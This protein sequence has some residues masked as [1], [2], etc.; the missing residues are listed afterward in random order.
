MRTTVKDDLLTGNPLDGDLEDHHIFPYCLTKS[1]LSSA[2][3][4]SI[5]NKIIVAKA[6]NRNISN[7]NPDKYLV[8][9]AND[10]INQGVDGDL[11]RRF[12]N[13]FI[14]YEPTDH[15]LREK[16]SKDNYDTFLLDRAELLL[17]RIREVV[18][19]SWQEPT[20][21]EVNLEDD[22]FVSA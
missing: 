4:N 7:S 18:G 12:K 2:K 15:N 3:L 5:V 11:A 21:G 8:S 17:S 22:E 14:P 6:T 1:G 19:E 10:H 20:T 13:S 16:L 9:L